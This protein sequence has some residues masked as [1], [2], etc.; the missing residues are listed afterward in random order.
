MEISSV[1]M[2]EGI[3]NITENSWAEIETVY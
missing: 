1:G 2:E 3:R